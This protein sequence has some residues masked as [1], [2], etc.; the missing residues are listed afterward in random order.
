MSPIAAP[1]YMLPIP[2]DPLPQGLTLPQFIQTVLA[3][4]TGLPGPL[5]RPK[6]QA[7]PPKQPDLSVDWLAFGINEDEGDDNA[8]VG[9]NA[10]GSAM[11][12]RH[13]GL[14]VGCKFTGPN[15]LRYVGFLRDGFQVQANRDAL[16]RANMGFTETS[17]AVAVPDLVNE[18]WVTAFEMSVSLRRQV[19][20][21]YP[22]VTLLS[23]GGTLQTVIGNEDYLLDW[24][25]Q[26]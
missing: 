17:R 7:K 14:T 3:G 6:W 12:Q 21:I 1:G 19:Q 15:A 16:T 24:N 26:N 2:G 5:V 22:I 11:L 4:I 20:R 9:Y 10:D 8:Y 25:A 13:V 18:Q 23:A